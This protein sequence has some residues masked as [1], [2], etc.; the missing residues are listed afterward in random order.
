[1]DK[2]SNEKRKR[3]YTRKTNEDNI[4]K[5]KTT[6]SII[7]D[8]SKIDNEKNNKIKKSKKVEIQLNSDDNDSLHESIN[9]PICFKIQKDF[10]GIQSNK[11]T[12]L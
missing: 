8:N 7:K 11:D 1:M 4:E 5:I 9:E 10:K 3:K 6:T 12:N 2:S